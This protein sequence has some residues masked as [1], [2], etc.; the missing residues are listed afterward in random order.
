MGKEQQALSNSP[1]RASG[2]SPA[3]VPQEPVQVRI[4]PPKDRG[5]RLPTNPHPHWF[6]MAPGA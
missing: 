5:L 3:G 4:V 2:L 1:L 6:G